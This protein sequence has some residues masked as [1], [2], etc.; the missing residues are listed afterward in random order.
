MIARTV[1]ALV[2][3]ALIGCGGDSRS[4]VE[5]PG[6]D[7]SRD[8]K[9]LEA[10]ASTLQED[11]PIEDIHLYLCGFHFYSGEMRRQV[12]AH[13][14]CSMVNDEFHQC[15]I[16]DGNTED[17]KLIGVE[18]VISERLFK[19]L[20]EE[21]KKLWHS[22]AYEVKAG[23]LT[24]PGLPDRQEHEVMEKLVATYGKTFHFWQVDRGDTLP[25][26]I[27]RLMMGFTRDGQIQPELLEARD[28]RFEISTAVERT[29]RT[30]IP[31]PQV[32]PAADAWQKGQVV[33]L[34]QVIGSGREGRARQAGTRRQGQE[35]QGQTPA[36][37]GQQSEPQPRQSEPR[38][39]EPEQTGP[40]E[41][42]SSESGSIEAEPPP[43]DATESPEL[44]EPRPPQ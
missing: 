3:L 44:G 6:R 43:S 28:R 37:D 21:E 22:H 9:L 4:L 33:E 5:S 41:R 2:A 26:G 20:P 12:E 29:E 14:F 1:P 25:L 40:Q 13:H 18:Y 30:D 35:Q 42:E 34:K 10:S 24:A 38:Q 8:S 17:A 7:V 15:V 19:T 36:P 27:P 31:T 16:Y 11:A 32:D 23:L 39:T